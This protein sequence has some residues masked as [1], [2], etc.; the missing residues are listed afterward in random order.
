MCKWISAVIA[1]GML[2]CVRGFF[3]TRGAVV[4]A[5]LVGVLVVVALLSPWLARDATT[6]DVEHGLTERGA[7]LGLTE[8]PP[9]GTDPLGR[10]VWERVAAGA[11][12]S[13]AVAGAA[14]AL[15]LLLGLAIGLVAGYAGGLADSLLMRFVDLVLAFPALL[16]AILLASLL[17]ESGL[18]GGSAPVVLTLALVGWTMPARVIRGRARMLARGEMVT[19]ARA[20]GASAL[21]IVVRHVLPNLAGI[22]IAVALIAFAEN[23]AAEAVLS[24]LGLGPPPPAPTWGRMFYEGRLYYRTAPHLVLAP[25]LAILAA[26]AGFH[27]LGEALDARL[28]R[29]A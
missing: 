26:V 17:R 18:A 28:G 19:A 8:H 14:T 3:A 7:P 20:V 27:L 29:R 10:D 6:L 21:R 1:S 11:A 2:Q 5:G 24:F 16:L 9:L 12:T 4:G 23:L 25:G 22:T 13:L 15:A